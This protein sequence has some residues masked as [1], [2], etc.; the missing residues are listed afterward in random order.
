MID[1]NH[2]YQKK[3]Y[4]CFKSKFFFIKTILFN[5]ISLKICDKDNKTLNKDSNTINNSNKTSL[6]LQ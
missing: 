1:H 3:K 4:N 2:I 6:L 5:I